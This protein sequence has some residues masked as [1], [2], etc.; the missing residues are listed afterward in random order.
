MPLNR[1]Q[2]SRTKPLRHR[3]EGAKPLT[4]SWAERASAESKGSALA[5]AA[6]LPADTLGAFDSPDSLR[7]RHDSRDPRSVSRAT[8]VLVL[9]RRASRRVRAANSRRCIRLP[10]Q[11]GWKN[12]ARPDRYASFFEAS[13]IR[14]RLPDRITAV[15]LLTL[16]L[17]SQTRIAISKRS[18]QLLATP[19]VRPGEQA[20][21]PLPTS[22]RRFPVNSAGSENPPKD[23]R[24]MIVG[25]CIRFTRGR[26]LARRIGRTRG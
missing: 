24:S 15:R 21:R 14:A 12:L 16:P 7:G 18:C 25:G 17:C 9:F 2:P 26:A 6:S 8:F 5:S 10:L 11:A 20:A 4:S 1:R 13:P 19:A 3:A 22:L 23:G